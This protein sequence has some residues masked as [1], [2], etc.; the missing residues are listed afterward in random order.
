MDKRAFFGKML[1]RAGIRRA[2]QEARLESAKPVRGLMN[3]G[4]AKNKIA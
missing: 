4:K 3:I 1:E 2:E